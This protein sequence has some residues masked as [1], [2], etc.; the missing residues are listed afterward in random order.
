[1]TLSNV[2]LHIGDTESTVAT[3]AALKVATTPDAQLLIDRLVRELL[4]PVFRSRLRSSETQTIPERLLVLNRQQNALERNCGQCGGA[5]RCSAGL[6]GRLGRVR[7][8]GRAAART[9]GGSRNDLATSG[10]DG[11]N[12]LTRSDC[13]EHTKGRA[14]AP[15][16]GRK[17]LDPLA[18][19]GRDRIQI[20]SNTGEWTAFGGG[21]GGNG[22]NGNSGGGGMLYQLPKEMPPIR[23]DNQPPSSTDSLQLNEVV[24]PPAGARFDPFGPPGAGSRDHFRLP[25]FGDRFPD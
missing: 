3:C 18:A 11:S 8:I 22:G 25:K 20:D 12:E 1:M 19:A 7:R 16:V 15:A 4:N 6:A 9:A 13:G 14:S 23:S 17:D 5:D 21:G 24:K 2:Q 10:R